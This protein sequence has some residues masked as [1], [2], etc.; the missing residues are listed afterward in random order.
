MS[1]G[2]VSPQKL[3]QQLESNDS[4]VTEV[5]LSANSSYQMKSGEFTKRIGDALLTNTH[6]KRLTLKNLDIDDQSVLHIAEALKTN[7][8]LEFLDLEKNKIGSA[9]AE[10]LANALRTNTTLTELVLL[11]NKEFGEQCLSAWIEFFEYNV[12]L[13]KITWRLNSRQSFTINKKIV[14]NNEIQKRLKNGTNYDEL[15]PKNVVGLQRSEPVPEHR[16]PRSGEDQSSTKD[17]VPR[18]EEEQQ[19]EQPQ[20]EPQQEDQPQ[21]DN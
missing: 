19:Q 5:D 4:S 20:E 21:E 9:G 1:K 8:T 11:G 13:L 6:V 14:R 16:E 10:A 2:F 18:V 17:P 15:L 7:K 3:V 12:H